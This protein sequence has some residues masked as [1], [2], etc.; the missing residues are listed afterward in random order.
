ML[1]YVVS[2]NDNAGISEHTTHEV[3]PFY[4]LGFC[5]NIT[6][7][8]TVACSTRLLE[9]CTNEIQPFHPLGICKNITH[10][11]IVAYSTRLLEACKMQR[12]LLTAAWL[13]LMGKVPVYRAG[14]S[15]SIP[16]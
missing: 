5:K 13:S 12:P 15:G 11:C 6:H 10:E 8:C 4:P 1:V 14:G 7:E 3:Q 9:A 16:G 2:S